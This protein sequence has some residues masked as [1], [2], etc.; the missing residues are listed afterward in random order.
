M[1][2]FANLSAVEALEAAIAGSDHL[3]PKHAFVIALAR[4]IA[5]RADLLNECGW[6]VDGKLDNVTMPTLLRYAD[7]LG[8]TL[9]EKA[10]PG[11]ASTAS[12]PQQAINEM[13]E[14]LRMV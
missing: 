3:K 2:E 9:S 8:L 5:A 1:A 7:A 13:R 11:P 6:V 14:R 12:E 10:K 4:Q